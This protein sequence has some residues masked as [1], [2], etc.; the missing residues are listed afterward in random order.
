MRREPYISVVI[1]TLNEERNITEAI[2]GIK[3]I[4][5]DLNY[6]IIVVDGGSTDNTV[7]YAKRAGAT[8][9]IVYE[10]GK[11][12][13]LRKGFEI[14]QGKI[15]I[16]IDADLSKRPEEI[17]LIVASIEMGYDMCMGSRFITGGGTEDISLLRKLGNKFFVGMVN[18]L[19]KTNYTDMCYGYRGF[20]RD[21]IKRLSLKEDG[22][23]IETEISIRSKLAGL[24][25]IEIPS[26]EKKRAYGNSNLK[27]FR[28]GYIILKTIVSHLFG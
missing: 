5:K 3:R 6:E 26:F 25:V 28:D 8:K 16:S 9:V 13:Q 17:K 12:R 27:T 10:K 1:P 20:R 2:K 14:A 11:G 15:I 24:R 4:I 18:I 23:G 21:V 7:E 19:Y 22:F